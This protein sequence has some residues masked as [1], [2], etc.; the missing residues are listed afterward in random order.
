MPRGAERA[1]ARG[2]KLIR[3]VK[4]VTFLSHD[5]CDCLPCS[6]AHPQASLFIFKRAEPKIFHF[7]LS[8]LLSFSCALSVLSALSTNQNAVFARCRARNAGPPAR[9]REDTPR[10][11]RRVARAVR[12]REC[13]PAAARRY[14]RRR[15][16][17]APAKRRVG[18]FL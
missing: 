7:C 6:E 14:S 16:A 15:V 8:A 18:E 5:H 3:S 13:A 1:T 10:R 9:A 12:S 4:Y 2:A 11:A 17:A